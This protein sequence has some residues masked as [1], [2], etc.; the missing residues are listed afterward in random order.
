MVTNY[1]TSQNRK[2][3]WFMK[4]RL[5][6]RWRRIEHCKKLVLYQYTDKKRIPLRDNCGF[7]T[8]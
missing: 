5:W 6:E 1:R 7:V 8:L 2:I 3:K 4:T